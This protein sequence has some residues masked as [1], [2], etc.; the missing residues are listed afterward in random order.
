MALQGA[1]LAKFCLDKE[2]LQKQIGTWFGACKAQ[3][4]HI[5][6]FPY[7]IGG[8]LIYPGRNNI[9]FGSAFQNLPPLVKKK[10]LKRKTNWG[11]YLRKSHSM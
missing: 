4:L 7:V 9:C 3:A 1:R 5:G 10:D 11:V 8:V 6:D 2:G